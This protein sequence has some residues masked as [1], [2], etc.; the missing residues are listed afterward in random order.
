MITDGFLGWT[1]ESAIKF[2]IPRFVYYGM[3]NFAG[4]VNSAVGGSRLILETESDDELFTVPN[5]PW[6][7]LTRND[8]ESPFTDREPGSPFFNFVMEQVAATA[9]SHGLIVNSYYELE[10]AYVDFWNRECQP[11]AW[12]IG[13][14]CLAQPPKAQPKSIEKPS[15]IVWLEEKLD[16][17]SPVL[18]VAFGSQA[19]VSSEQFE[20]IKIGLE[21]SEANFLWVV[22]KIENGFNDGFEER[23]KGRGLVVREWVDQREILGHEAVKGFLSHCGWNS[24]LESICA[25]VPILAWPM[26]AEQHL[27]ARMVVEEIKIGIRVETSDGSVRG[28]VKWQGLEKTVRELMEGE[29]GK[30]VRKKVKEMS[31]AAIKAV[32]EG[33]SS[34]R[35]LNELILELHDNGVRKSEVV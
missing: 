9:K 2:N 6:L 35:T 19:E 13:P 28:F 14:F 34:W 25:E 33:G 10:P 7:K 32:E 23:V 12:S 17:G 4:A 21:K 11:K 31:E 20:E 24:V 15:W 27:N 8:F 22:R 1:L 26:M 5:F 30:E 18:Y 29:M 16:H 3:S